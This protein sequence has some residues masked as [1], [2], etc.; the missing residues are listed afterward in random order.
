MGGSIVENGNP[1]DPDLENNLQHYMYAIQILIVVT[2]SAHSSYSDNP[3]T[4]GAILLA[5]YFLGVVFLVYSIYKTTMRQ[6][7]RN[8]LVPAEDV[9]AGHLSKTTQALKKIFDGMGGQ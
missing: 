7:R 4:G 1:A 2:I 8:E 5:F 9:E 6:R 3:D